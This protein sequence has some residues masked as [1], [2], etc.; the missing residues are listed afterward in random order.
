MKPS[1]KSIINA[2]IEVMNVRQYV[3]Y[4]HNCFQGTNPEQ[5]KKSFWF[6]ETVDYIEFQN[7][8]E[9]APDLNI[10]TQDELVFILSRICGMNQNVPLIWLSID[11]FGTHADVPYFHVEGMYEEA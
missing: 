10:L 4:R 11:T 5:T 2:I 6:V 9:S 3:W 1:K 7:E 8:Y